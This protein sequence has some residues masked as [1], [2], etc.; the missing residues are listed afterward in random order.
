MG[1][2]LIACHECD[3]LQRRVPIRGK[4]SIRCRRCGA[5][6]YRRVPH[7][8]DRVAALALAGLVLFVAANA[9]PLLSIRIGQQVMSAQLPLAVRSLWLHGEPAL[10]LLVGLTC[11]GIPGLVLYLMLHL[12]VPLRLGYTPLGAIPI[13]RTLRAIQQWNMM[14]VFLL[15]ILVTAVKLMKMATVIPGLGVAAFFALIF[16]LAA[17]TNAMDPEALWARL[18]SRT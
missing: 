4:G 13:L 8:A 14:E 7:A 9:L 1:T 12:F 5:N 16:V 2:G 18:E 11:I 3:F 10:A 17:A 15:G 6:L